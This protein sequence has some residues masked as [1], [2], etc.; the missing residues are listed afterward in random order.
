MALEYSS[1]EYFVRQPHSMDEITDEGKTLSHC[2]GGYAQ[3]H[4][5]GALN[6]L[7]IRKTDDPDTPLYTMEL[8]TEGKVVQVRGLNNCD[9]TKDAKTFV[10]EYKK[11]IAPLFERQKARKTA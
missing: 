1:G 2:V 11:Y 7:F 6:I 5:K 9:P 4:A 3:R 8:S 10:E